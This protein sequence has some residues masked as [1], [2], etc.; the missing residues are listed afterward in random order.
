[1][2]SRLLLRRGTCRATAAALVAPRPLEQGESSIAPAARVRHQRST[3]TEATSGAHDRL[4]LRT[5]ATRSSDNS[6]DGSGSGA[7]ATDRR[8]WRGSRPRGGAAAR[9]RGGLVGRHRVHEQVEQDVLPASARAPA[10]SEGSSAVRVHVG[11]GRERVRG[12]EPRPARRS[13][14][15]FGRGVGALSWKNQGA[16]RRHR[17]GPVPWRVRRDGQSRPRRRAS[18]QPPLHCAS[19]GAWPGAFVPRPV[20]LVLEQHGAA[21]SGPVAARELGAARVGACHAVDARAVRPRRAFALGSRVSFGV[22][23]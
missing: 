10:A 20:R 5:A 21:G 22:A 18:A 6:E 15:Q 23:G 4:R 2:M 12:G 3:S 17:L 9:R 19:R 8:Q 7:A 1:M 14:Q 11:S 13:G 16:V